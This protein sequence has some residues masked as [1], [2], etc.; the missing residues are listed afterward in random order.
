MHTK[1]VGQPAVSL[2]S[3]DQKGKE[4]RQATLLWGDPVHVVDPEPLPANGPVN[5]IA[6]AQHG[7]LDASELTDIGLLEL[8]ITDV[9]QGDA[10]LIRTPDDR[11]HL[12]DGG[13]SYRSQ[14]THTSAVNFLRWKFLEDLLLEQ[15][16]LW[17]VIL[18]HPDEDHYAGLVDVF[19]G[20][21]AFKPPFPIHVENFY[22]NGIGRYKARPKLGEKVAGQVAAF[23][24][25]GHGIKAK[26]R[27]ITGLLDGA[28]SFAHPSRAFD[29]DFAKLAEQ[30]AVAP[31]S[32]RRLSARDAYLPGYGPGENAVTI[33]ILG[34]IFEDLGG[35]QS[36]LR[37]LDS[38]EEDCLTRNGHSIT[39][40]I[41][42]G[43]ARILLAGDL[44]TVSQK[45]LLSYIPEAEFAVDVG[46]A[47]HHGGEDVD[48]S[49]L[50]AMQARATVISSGDA[51]DYAH[52]RPLLL[53]MAGRYG[54]DWCG[55]KG[56]ALPPLIYA[57]E[58]ARSIKTAN[59]AALRANLGTSTQPDVRELEPSKAEIALD[60]SA[61]RF[62]NLSHAAVSSKLVYGLVNVRTD[63][64]QILCATMEEK[65]NDFTWKVFPA[66][67]DPA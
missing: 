32:V 46:K 12:I 19:K 4:I 49:F 60:G 15:V 5:V 53:G 64:R 16:T 50:K 45:L 35:G 28:D 52:P 43:N 17:D 14:M 67:V 38:G 6:R 18:S 31:R 13:A 59:P 65:G 3:R 24:Q 57:T 66:G 56:E 20:E 55:P 63:G 34:P 62:S 58:L 37:Y 30:I 27:F 2:H 8:Y 54:R 40:R 25:G 11:W 1:Y 42:Y 9:G 7:Y 41:D 39:L 36:G 47:C 48:P 29:A 23:P 44:N 26:A 10:I 21:T 22:H 33:R 51:E 61:G